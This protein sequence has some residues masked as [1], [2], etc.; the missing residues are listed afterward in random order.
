MS[1]TLPGIV[2]LVSDIHSLNVLLLIL[3]TLFGVVMPVNDVQLLK[4]PSPI[5]MTFFGIVIAV[6]DLHPLNALIPILVT[7]NGGLKNVLG[8]INCEKSVGLN[9]TISAE[10]PRF[11]TSKPL[12]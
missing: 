12:G 1:L 6:S 11:L 7:C 10:F 2:I 8:M 3:V 9:F 5:F 4:A